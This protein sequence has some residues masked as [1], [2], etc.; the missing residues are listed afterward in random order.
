MIHAGSR[1]RLPI[2]PVLLLLAWAGPMPKAGATAAGMGPADARRIASYRIDVTL[3]PAAHTLRGT[4]TLTWRNATAR[5]TSE[6][7]LHLYLNGFKNDRSTFMKES[8]GVSRGHKFKD[9]EWGWIDITRM[10]LGGG[11][12]LRAGAAFIH[13][14]DDNTEDETVLRVPLPR[15]V[16]PGDSIEVGLEFSARLPRVFARTGYLTDFHMV[17]QWFPKVGV[18][19]DSGWNCH[20]FHG[21]GEFFSDFGSY[22]VTIHVPQEY[23]VGATGRLQGQPTTSG[24]VTT[25]HFAQDDVH[26]FAWTADPDFV[27]EVRWFRAAEQRDPEEEARMAA[28]LGIAPDDPGLRLSDVEVTVLL[29]PE[30]RHLMDRHFAAAFAAI[31]YFGYWYGRYPYATLTVVDPPWR[32][33]GA[34]GMEYPTLITA[35]ASVVAPARRQSPESVTIHEFGHQYWYGMVATNEFE[36]AFLD[37]GFN[38]Y[39]TGKVLDKVYGP[40]HDTLELAPGL[41]YVAQPLLEIPRGADPVSGGSGPEGAAWLFDVLLM[42]PFGPSDDLALNTLRDLPFLNAVAEA[43]LDQVTAQRRRYLGEPTA[44]NLSRRAWQYMNTQVYGLNSYARTALVLRTL[45]GILGDATMRRLMRAWFDRGRYRHPRVEDFIALAGE[46]SG[47]D[48]EPFFRQAVFGSDLLDY[49]VESAASRKVKPGRGVFGPPEARRTVTAPENGAE[50]A[51]D[52]DAFDSEVLVRRRGGF[53]WPQEIL[54]R[55]GAG[56]TETVAWDGAYRWTRLQR[57]GPRLDSARLDP[58]SR[59]ALDANRSNNSAARDKQH[60]PAVRW[61][62]R[63]L[64]W[65]QHVSYFYS[66]IS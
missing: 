25:W 22:D 15:A 55:R 20:Q 51:Q 64:Q 52:G 10:Q 62:S 35:G 58:E 13:P 28:A 12:D 3:D 30:H 6:L 7:Q 40:N 16:A 17:A 53:V 36:E 34:G 63:L 18:L 31:K 8:K 23:V 57:Q 54:L 27:K 9:G 11:E 26:D 4:E 50:A 39:S 56:Q 32:G 59:L 19:E 48:L 33:R 65:M 42:R 1:L 44:D 2:A 24:G 49:S 43:P 37:E 29:H 60:L 41:N 61:W 38:T 66:G 14:D 21:S 45:E 47:R 46:I 5:P